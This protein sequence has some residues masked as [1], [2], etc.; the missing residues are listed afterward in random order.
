M[1]HP[2]KIFTTLVLL[3]LLA[4]VA[5][6]EWIRV[7][8]CAKSEAPC[9]ASDIVLAAFLSL[10]LLSQAVLAGWWLRRNRPPPTQDIEL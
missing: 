5:I 2:C 1:E 4:S 3:S 10:V 7:Y 9:A 6:N 8:E